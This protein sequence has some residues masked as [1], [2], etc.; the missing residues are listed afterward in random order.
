[1]PLGYSG[2]C[3]SIKTSGTPIRRPRGQF[4]KH[5]YEGLRGTRTEVVYRPSQA[6]DYKLEMGVFI[7]M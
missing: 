1:M 4:F 5:G 6:L 3:S 2:R 7:G